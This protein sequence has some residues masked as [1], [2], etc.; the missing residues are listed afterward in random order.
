MSISNE[1]LKFLAETAISK[2]ETN[3]TMQEMLRSFVF[4]IPNNKKWLIIPFIS[5]TKLARGSITFSQTANFMITP[6][7]K[8]D[9][10]INETKVSYITLS[11]ALETIKSIIP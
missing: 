10:L 11:L 8:K 5:M 4:L 6:T 9:S 1:D 7:F 2:I 3:K